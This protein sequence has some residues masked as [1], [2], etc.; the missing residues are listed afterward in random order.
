MPGLFNRQEVPHMFLVAP[1]AQKKV[2]LGYLVPFN[3]A[4][5]R[6]SWALLP[7]GCCADGLV[8]DVAD[9]LR[10]LVGGVT[11]RC[12]LGSSVRWIV[13]RSNQSS[14]SDQRYSTRLPRLMNLGPVPL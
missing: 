3:R 8:D 14:T 10:E 4:C 6:R 11:H 9:G 5:R 13:L 12:G 1:W 2:F 7:D